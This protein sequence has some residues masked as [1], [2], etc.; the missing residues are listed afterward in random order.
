MPLTVRAARFLIKLARTEPDP[1]DLALS[2]IFHHPRYT[3]GSLDEK[4]QIQLESARFRYDY[5]QEADRLSF[6]FP[7]VPGEL[8][9]KRV[10]DLGC[11]T[12]GRLI[13][14]AEKY[15]FATSDGIDVAPVYIEAAMRFAALRAAQPGGL[16]GPRM[17]RFVVGVGEQLPYSDASFD[18]IISLDVFEHVQ[19]VARVMAEC[20]RVLAPGGMLLACFPQFYQPTESHLN[21][22]TRMHGLHCIFPGKSLA[23]AIAEESRER[24]PEAEWYA[25]HGQEEWERSPFLN[26]ITLQRFRRIVRE[27]R[28]TVRIWARNPI[29]TDGRR[30]RLPVYRALRTLL[31]PLARLPLLE[32][33]FLG[34][35]CCVL[36]RE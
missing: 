13:A 36:R 25:Y 33:V 4:A 18:A 11:F 5:E 30:A 10:L 27:Q 20:H 8:H 2:E 28:W 32:E 16:G 12:G 24:G 19:D 3:R 34:R 22:F 21:M 23:Q 6:Y 35:V 7:G 1:H 9:G 26:G 14:W 15:G 31:V 17:P 29:L